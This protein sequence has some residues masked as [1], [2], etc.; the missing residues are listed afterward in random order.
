MTSPR[1]RLFGV[2]RHERK[3]ELENVDTNVTLPGQIQNSASSSASASASASSWFDE[4]GVGSEP[5]SASS[6]TTS[7]AQDV[8]QHIVPPA[9]L[10]RLGAEWER[11]RNGNGLRRAKSSWT[12]GTRGSSSKMGS[13][14]SG[15]AHMGS[16]G[17][18]SKLPR[19]A[20]LLSKATSAPSFSSRA[21]ETAVSV[22]AS[23]GGGGASGGSRSA[24]GHTSLSPPPPR[25]T[26]RS[27]V[28]NMTN[29]GFLS[30]PPPRRAP[31]S[32]SAVVPP[33]GALIERK[34]S[35]LD[36]SSRQ[37]VTLDVPPPPL[38]LPLARHEHELERDSFLELSSREP[39]TTIETIR[40]SMSSVDSFMEEL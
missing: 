30:P 21:D 4:R 13:S 20:S 28:R 29:T 26:Q 32:A 24:D 38:P 36:M 16:N 27:I 9:E 19:S 7:I 25:R 10:L 8:A 14:R 37:S 15:E 6:T 17:G 1:R 12:G 22:S 34:P 11:E 3:Q 35:F 23:V 2:N 18:G 31:S 39:G 40:E 33:K 5:A